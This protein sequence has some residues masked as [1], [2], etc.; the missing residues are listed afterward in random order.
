MILGF[1]LL[2]WKEQKDLKD[3]R[4]LRKFVIFIIAGVVSL[5]LVTIGILYLGKYIR[6]SKRERISM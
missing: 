3:R 6:E 2:R 5:L 1:L 4:T